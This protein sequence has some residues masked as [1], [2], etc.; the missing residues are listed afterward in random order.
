MRKIAILLSLAMVLSASARSFGA[1]A[2]WSEEMDAFPNPARWGAFAGKADGNITTVAGGLIAAGGTW[3]S[4]AGAGGGSGS[5]V[6][7]LG[8][9]F[10]SPA[11]PSPAANLSS[12]SFEARFRLLNDV[13]VVNGNWPIE[14][15]LDNFGN[16]PTNFRYGRRN[17]G[18][19]TEEQTNAGTA[20]FIQKN[21][22]PVDTAWH[23]L[24]ITQSNG[25]G[26]N[27]IANWY[28]DGVLHST[29]VTAAP[30]TARNRSFAFRKDIEVAPNS[31]GIE[32]DYFRFAEGVVPINEEITAAVPEPATGLLAL[33]GGAIALYGR[34][35]QA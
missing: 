4:P 20:G 11:T 17:A 26:P 24:R 30:S 28:V 10:S 14:M 5:A 6:I 18:V 16:T 33:V 2:Y 23:V 19:T 7:G 22:I 25:A 34:R 13:P 12:F 35:R 29:F 8:G 27:S 1:V 21:D 15:T 31:T 9:P 3:T 32:Y